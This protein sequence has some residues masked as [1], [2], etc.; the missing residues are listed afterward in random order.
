MQESRSSRLRGDC[1]IAETLLARWERSPNRPC[2]PCHRLYWGSS[3]QDVR[4]AGIVL[5]EAH[6]RPQVSMSLEKA[7]DPFCDQICASLP[8]QAAAMHV[9]G[10]QCSQVG[11]QNTFFASSW[12]IHDE[13]NLTWPKGS[14]CKPWPRLVVTCR[15][16]RIR[17]KTKKLVHKRVSFTADRS[18]SKKSAD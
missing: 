9:L 14:Y 1:V 15:L 10:P 8:P 3:C 11:R 18:K 13:L 16:S 5:P 7:A 17:L 4:S 2:R 12:S 6:C